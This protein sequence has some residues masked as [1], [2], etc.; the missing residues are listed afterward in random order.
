MRVTMTLIGAKSV[1]EVTGDCLALA[2]KEL[3]R[4]QRHAAAA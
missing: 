2:E 3:A 1:Q 4:P